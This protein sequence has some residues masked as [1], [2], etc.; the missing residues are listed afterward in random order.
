M[1]VLLTSA[2]WFTLVPRSPAGQR[3]ASGVRV[4]RPVAAWFCVCVCP[5]H[6]SCG[7][8]KQRR[9]VASPSQGTPRQGA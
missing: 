3:G 8:P 2:T 9:A 6:R 7:D 5:L 4:V 1:R